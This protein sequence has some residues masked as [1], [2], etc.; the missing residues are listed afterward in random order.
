MD[1]TQVDTQN[2]LYD[3]SSL[4]HYGPTEMSKD[5]SLT[6]EALQPNVKIGQ[7]FYLSPTD[8]QGVRTYYGCTATGSTLP[9]STTVITTAKSKN[10]VS[11]KNRLS[12]TKRDYMRKYP[13]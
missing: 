6:V 3:Y 1:N 9:P 8:I 12:D 2:A 5:G 4:M 10:I 7:R 13:I 11:S